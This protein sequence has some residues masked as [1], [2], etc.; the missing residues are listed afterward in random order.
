MICLP[1]EPR[2]PQ[3]V[4]LL[5]A[6]KSSSATFPS[7]ST[8]T[9]TSTTPA[10]CLLVRSVLIQLWQ[11]LHFPRI[12][13]SMP[14]PCPPHPHPHPHPHQ[15]SG[16]VDNTYFNVRDSIFPLTFSFRPVFALVPPSM[17]P[18]HSTPT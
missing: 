1:T 11:L 5:C 18:F 15:L 13:Q 4:N 8:G 3:P 16:A 12:Y 9:S 17:P 10:D 2:L 7:Y 14:C 6:G